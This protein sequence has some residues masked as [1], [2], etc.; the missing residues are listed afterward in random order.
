MSKFVRHTHC[1]VAHDKDRRMS[2]EK[3]IVDR[4][5]NR[6]CVCHSNIL[7]YVKQFGKAIEARLYSQT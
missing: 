4:R 5:G 2:Y 1:N 7:Q 3:I 6:S